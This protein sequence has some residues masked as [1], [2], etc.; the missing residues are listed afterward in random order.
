M[1]FKHAPYP[2]AL[3]TSVKETTDTAAAVCCSAWF[4]GHLGQ[5]QLRP[6]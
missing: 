3:S 2:E 5:Q 1:P 4:G 6:S